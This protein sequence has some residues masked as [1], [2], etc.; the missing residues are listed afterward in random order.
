MQ[1]TGGPGLCQPLKGLGF[2][3]HWRPEQMK[4]TRVGRL[5]SL[6][7]ANVGFQ[8]SSRSCLKFV[9]SGQAGKVNRNFTATEGARQ[10]AFTPAWGAYS[11]WPRRQNPFLTIYGNIALA[12]VTCGWSFILIAHECNLEAIYLSSIPCH[13]LL[14]DIRK[15]AYQTL[16]DHMENSNHR[17]DHN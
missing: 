1:S 10:V 8:L 14:S 4:T 17:T 3:W 15:G 5:P 6:G 9:R 13:S 7:G 16:A 12:T 11:Y 2:P